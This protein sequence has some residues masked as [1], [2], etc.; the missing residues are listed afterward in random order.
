MRTSERK[1]SHG[2]A[3]RLSSAPLSDCA[4]ILRRMPTQAISP[5]LIELLD[6]LSSPILLIECRPAGELI[7]MPPIRPALAEAA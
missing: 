1:R 3:P 2:G 7:E 4:A 6:M 5:A